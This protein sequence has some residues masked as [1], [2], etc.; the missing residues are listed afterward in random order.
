[1]AKAN[2]RQDWL[3][4]LVNRFSE[5]N[6]T[7]FAARVKMDPSV[8]NMLVNGKRPITEKTVVKLCS[9]LN[10][11]PPEP[12]Q[13]IAKES[14][15]SPNVEQPTPDAF[16]AERA[17]YLRMIDTLQDQ[18]DAAR[19]REAQYAKINPEVSMHWARHTFAHWAAREK[20]PLDL[21]RQILGHSSL[22][23]TQRYMMRV[24]REGIRK[25]FG[26]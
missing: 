15:A 18:L 9:R 6:V 26:T 14:N 25:V 5:G 8:M 1:M 23:I 10:V 3:R 21:L 7:A 22:S 19:E 17:Q 12:V 4:A 24:D 2:P 20:V 16:A 11:E 13:G